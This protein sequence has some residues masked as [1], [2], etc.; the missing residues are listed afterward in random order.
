MASYTATQSGNWSATATWGGSGP[1]VSGDTANIPGLSRGNV[2]VTVDVA[3]ACD[4]IN[5]TYLQSAHTHGLL[6]IAPGI[7]LT[8]A[9]SGSGN[10]NVDGYEAG[11]GATT[12]HIYLGAG[13]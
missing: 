13:S 7:T 3:S 12:D 11:Y 9:S 1:P 5:Q 4:T 8:V 10:H 2:T 6:V